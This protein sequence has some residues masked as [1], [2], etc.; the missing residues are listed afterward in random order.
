MGKAVG[1]SGN[2]TPA[3][4]LSGDTGG[5]LRCRLLPTSLH[6]LTSPPPEEAA[7]KGRARSGEG[8]REALLLLRVSSVSSEE[9]RRDASDWIGWS[10]SEA[11][12]VPV[13]LPASPVPLCAAARRCLLGRGLVR[14]GGGSGAPFPDPAGVG[15]GARWGRPVVSAAVVAGGSW[16]RL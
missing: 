8:G 9:G 14:G 4:P 11:A 1:S 16:C 13:S 12:L 6:P 7:G 10:G 15:W 5:T 2:S 3:S